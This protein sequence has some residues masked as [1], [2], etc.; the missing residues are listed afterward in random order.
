VLP[1]VDAGLAEDAYCAALLA[2]RQE[3]PRE[4]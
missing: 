2:G 1:F 4:G 3:H